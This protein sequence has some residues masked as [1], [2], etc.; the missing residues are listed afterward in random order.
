MSFEWEVTLNLMLFVSFLFLFLF[1]CPYEK[2]VD[3]VMILLF[4]T[5]RIQTSIVFGFVFFSFWWVMQTGM[6]SYTSSR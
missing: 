3:P 5:D 2:H 4:F 6:E 1:V